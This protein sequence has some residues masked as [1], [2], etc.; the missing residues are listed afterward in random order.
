MAL[1][2]MLLWEIQLGVV[3]IARKT[4]YNS[5]VYFVCTHTKYMISGDCT[6]GMYTARIRQVHIAPGCCH[7]NQHVNHATCEFVIVA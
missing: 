5:H 3:C 6:P 7:T 4:L 1:W 2:K